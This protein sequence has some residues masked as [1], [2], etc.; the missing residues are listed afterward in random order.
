[1]VQA[2]VINALPGP[3]K[4]VERTRCHQGNM[5]PGPSTLEILLT[6]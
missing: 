3:P 2:A 1:M 6:Y 4:E 5:R